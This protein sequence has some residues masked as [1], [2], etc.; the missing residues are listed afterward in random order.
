[1]PEADRFTILIPALNEAHNIGGLLDDIFDQELDDA[2]ALSRVVIVSDGSTDGTDEI[3]KARAIDDARI[4]LVSNPRTVGQFQS[5]NIG[6]RHAEGD[7]LVMLDAD[8]RLE[9]RRTLRN[10]LAGFTD[11]GVGL[12]SGMIAPAGQDR[13]LT[14]HVSRA[15]LQLSRNIQSRVRGGN[16][17]FA[18]R[19]A[20]MALRKDL[21]SNVEVPVEK[22]ETLMVSDDQFLYLSCIVRGMRFVSRPDAVVLHRYPDSFADYLRKSARFVTSLNETASLLEER[23]LAGEYQIPLSVK[24]LAYSDLLR[25]DLTGALLWVAYRIFIRMLLL[26]RRWQRVGKIWEVKESARVKK[27]GPGWEPPPRRDDG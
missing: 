21:Y 4:T 1:M 24:V 22:V 18:S 10:L 14:A 11:P 20:I 17:V 2:P 9:T 6:M 8:I 26:A 13:T 25:S 16:N 27:A 5:K 7:Y 19:G 12:V 15:G 23:D 3:V